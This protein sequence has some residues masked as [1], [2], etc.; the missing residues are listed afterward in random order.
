MI[1]GA[2][3]HMLEL[4]KRLNREVFYPIIHCSSHKNLDSWCKKFEDLKIP[5]IRSIARNKHN[6]RHYFDILK[7]IED[8]GIDLVHAH[9]WNPASNRYAYLATE[10][11]KKPLVTTEHDPFALSGIKNW[12]KKKLINKVSHLIT[13]SE[14]NHELI[15]KLYPILRG[16]I[17]TI[18]NGL[19]LVWF[20]SQL[21]S[22]SKSQ[23]EK[24]R[25]EIFE[26]QD[27]TTKVI[28]AVAEL[29]QRKGLNY[30]IEAAKILKEKEKNIIVVIVGKG[31]EE[32]SLKTQIKKLK[33]E[34]TV[35]LLGYRKDIP[36]L[37]ASSDIFTLP[38]L[39]EAFGLVLLEAM[40][41]KLPIVAT[42]NGGVPEIITNH[43]NGILV[44][45]A[46]AKQLASALLHLIDNKELMQKMAEK[47]HKELIKKFDINDMVKKTEEVYRNTLKL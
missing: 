24:I 16:K 32:K 31:K 36:H 27:G 30:L 38:S 20:Q 19:D 4:A 33:L 29:H 3:Q 35:K 12:I 6:P 42:K 40:A 10:K 14:K 5:V 2:E 22:F 18:H 8:F 25:R 41:A 9:I 26:V 46:S 23:R 15:R 7:S 39:N 28:I 21:L 13:V 45:P 17:T 44:P 43:E 11:T 37:L 1:G 34:N 47:G